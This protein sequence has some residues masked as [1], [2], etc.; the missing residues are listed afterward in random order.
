MNKKFVVI[1]ASAASIGFISKL[2]S[3]DKDSQIICF[4]G[5]KSRPYN[6][7]FLADFVTEEK[8]FEDLALK[9]ESFFDDNQVDLRLDTWV[10]SINREDKTISYGDGQTESYDYLFVG[11]GTRPFYPNIEGLD[12][13]EV[14]G[15]HNFEDVEKLH[16]FLDMNQ[17]KTAA[18]VG[19]GINGVEAVSSLVDRGLQVALIEMGP[20]A[21][22]GQ[23][24]KKTAQFIE[25]LMKHHNVVTYFNQSVSAIEEHNDKISRIKLSSGAYLSIDC[26]VF[27]TGNSINTDL[28]EKAGLELFEQ[29]LRVNNALQS[30]DP[31]IYAGGDICAAPDMVSKDVVRSATWPDAML[32][33]LCAATQF[34][35]KPR[36]YPG[37]VGMRDSYFFGMQFYACGST[38]EADGIQVVEKGK[39]DWMHRFYLKDGCL[40]GFVLCGNADR[41]ADYKRMYMTQCCIEESAL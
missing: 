29:S 4:S 40:K 33:G 12:M 27:A 31:V 16:Q 24:D 23:V 22:P 34:S 13:P 38:V 18:V 17:V 6:R 37:V 39:K 21:M 30:S 2:R 8:D 36:A 26:V 10:T 35:D 3:F 11:T 9:P 1:G 19:A 7:C 28:I 15:F 25:K 32:Q 41:L 14:F 5:E 20:S